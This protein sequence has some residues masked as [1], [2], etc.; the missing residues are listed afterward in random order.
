MARCAAFSPLSIP[1]HATGTPLGIWTMD[2]SA[3][4]P[5]SLADTGTPITGF[6][7]R[8]ATTPGRAAA[9]PGDGDE[10]LCVSLFDI[11]VQL[12]RVPVSRQHLKVIRDAILRQHFDGPVRNGTIGGGAEDDS[13]V[14]HKVSDVKRGLR[15]I[16]VGSMAIFRQG[17]PLKPE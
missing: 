15:Y 10:D 7:V 13:N 16:I 9:R 8:A 14:Y 12:V 5:P 11:G 1:T 6:L 4:R 3:S 17:F 2:S